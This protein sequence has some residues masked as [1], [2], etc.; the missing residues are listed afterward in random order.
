MMRIGVGSSILYLSAGTNN[1]VKLH[2]EDVEILETDTRKQIEE[3]TEE[4]LQRAMDL[5]DIKSIALTKDE[6]LIV[7]LASKYILAGY[8]ILKE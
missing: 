8:F 2:R 6:K 7:M 1:A 5:L 4:E 3:M